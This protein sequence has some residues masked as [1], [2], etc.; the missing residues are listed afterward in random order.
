MNGNMGK[1]MVNSLNKEGKVKTKSKTI[2]MDV[3]AQ[4]TL[5]RELAEMKLAFMDVTKKFKAAEERHNAEKKELKAQIE[6]AISMARNREGLERKKVSE[7]EFEFEIDKVVQ[8][9]NRHEGMDE[10]HD[11]EY[12]QEKEGTT[13]YTGTIPKTKRDILLRPTP[14]EPEWKDSLEKTVQKKRGT[15]RQ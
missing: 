6:M 15:T 9:S 10:E 3:E 1:V 5:K 2:K 8:L 12:D 14:K 13:K 11:N 7:G 4:S